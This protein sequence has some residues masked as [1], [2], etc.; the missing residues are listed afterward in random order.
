M[1]IIAGKYK[2]RQIA[3]PKHIRPTQDKVRQSIFDVLADAVKGSRALDIF[4]GS[5]ALG[6]EA[7]SRGASGVWFID[8]DRKCSLIIDKNLEK[9]GIT[10]IDSV[11]IRN[12][13][14]DAFKAIKILQKKKERFD[15]VFLD[16]PYHKGLAKKA[17]KTLV[18]SGILAACGFVI[19]EHFRKDDLGGCPEGLVL[20][21]E[22]NYGDIKVSFFSATEGPSP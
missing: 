6:L 1:R 21:R 13:T 20:I 12:F 17:L 22:I 7:L 18:G 11:D 8:I 16:P 19:V 3:F 10:K 5:G 2:G 9:L 14:N 15:V 4:A